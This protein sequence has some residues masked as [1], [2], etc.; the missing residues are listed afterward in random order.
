MFSRSRVARLRFLTEAEGG[1]SRPVTSGIR[2]MLGIGGQRTSC[3]VTSVD[4]DL[5]ISAGV[6][7]DV[8]IQIMWPEH[9]GREFAEL[10]VAELFDGNTLMA[11]GTFLP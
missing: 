7:V 4:G 8:V 3:I 11:I 9:N 2:P 10:R 1:W 6:D 5:V